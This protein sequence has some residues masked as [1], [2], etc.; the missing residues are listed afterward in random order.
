MKILFFARTKDL[1]GMD[2]LELPLAP[3]CTV[4]E[5]RAA[6]QQRIP[7]LAALLSKCAIALD[8]NFAD[9]DQPLD[10]ATEAAVLPPVSGG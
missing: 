6:L 9:D 4:R 2:Q 10:E 5:L 8:G 7:A 1:A 3:N